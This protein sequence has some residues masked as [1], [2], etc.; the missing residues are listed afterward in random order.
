MHHGE[1]DTTMESAGKIEAAVVLTTFAMNWVIHLHVYAISMVRLYCQSDKTLMCAHMLAF[2]QHFTDNNMGWR[3]AAILVN[4]LGQFSLHGPEMERI[5]Y[6]FV[7]KCF[8]LSLFV[9]QQVVSLP[10][11]YSYN[12]TPFCL[13]TSH[14][15]TLMEKRSI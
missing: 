13:A 7:N 6:S 11:A 14:T 2:I 9:W 4:I 8:A 10:C 15:S 12:I 3:P 1:R 5:L